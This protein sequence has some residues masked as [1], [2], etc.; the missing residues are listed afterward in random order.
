[1]AGFDRE[2]PDR[3]DRAE[4]DEALRELGRMAAERR[5]EVNMT[6][7]DIYDRTRIRPD[8]LQGIER[9]D[10]EGFPEP[11]YVKGFVRTYLKII[12]AEDLEEEFMAQLNRAQPHKEAATHLMGTGAFPKGFKPAS[13]LW[14][15]LVLLA[16]L[17]GTG[18]YV[19]YAV[20]H[21]MLNWQDL[22]WPNGITF[23]GERQGSLSG[24][25]LSMDLRP[26]SMEVLPI[27]VDTKPK[28][29]AK[30]KLYLELRAVNS[31]VWLQVTI[32]SDTVYSQTMR[33]G[34]RVSWDLPAQARVRF[35]RGN[36]TQVILNGKDL[37]IV[38]NKG[39]YL[40]MPDGTSR[41]AG[42]GA[43][44]TGTANR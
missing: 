5:E 8:Y 36:V 28:A 23:Q 13:H 26:A 12:G 32:G 42:A 11:V 4:R 9:G 21:G 33:R 15:F 38:K 2:R 44:G 41:R 16:A 7:E 30:P 19:W 3:S 1:M 14:L 20:S 35:G 25:V 40:Y 24:D 10:Y 37:G 18:G 43:G 17:L 22:H 31:D 39:T 29:P 27:S 34:D 6:L